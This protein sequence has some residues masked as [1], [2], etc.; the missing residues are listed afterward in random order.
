M[1][2]GRMIATVFLG[3]RQGGEKR[4]EGPGIAFPQHSAE[5]VSG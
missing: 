1:A 5:S 4:S 3:E 2:Q